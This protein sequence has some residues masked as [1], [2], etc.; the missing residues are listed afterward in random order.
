MANRNITDY[1]NFISA[2]ECY[3]KA[4]VFF[5]VLYTLHTKRKLT[6]TRKTDNIMSIN[7]KQQVRLK[8]PGP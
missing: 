7:C 5:L 2:E 1:F 6:K 8:H 4:F 3:Y